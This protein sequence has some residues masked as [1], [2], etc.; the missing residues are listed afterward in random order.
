M[1]T[2]AL[3]MYELRNTESCKETGDR[4]GPPLRSW[5]HIWA[6][7]AVRSRDGSTQDKIP[8]CADKGQD[9]QQVDG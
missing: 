8:K 1:Q 9:H 2:L 5:Q 3:M 4:V 7:C 6:H